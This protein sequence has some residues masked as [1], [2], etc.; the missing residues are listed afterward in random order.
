MKIHALDHPQNL[1]CRIGKFNAIHTTF[2]FGKISYSISLRMEQAPYDREGYS[3]YVFRFSDNGIGMSEEFQ[4][5]I[6]QPFERAATST[7]SK[8]EGTGLGMSI[9]KSIV[10]LMGAVF[11]SPVV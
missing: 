2:T 11:Q 4:K 9:T 8:T 5:V 1:Y 7:V 6:F 3:L 10:D